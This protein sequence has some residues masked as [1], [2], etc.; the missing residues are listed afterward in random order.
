MSPYAAALAVVCDYVVAAAEIAVD[1]VDVADV[2]VE[3][4]REWRRE[5]ALKANENLRKIWAYS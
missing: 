4:R 2:V 3:V 5:W 1:V